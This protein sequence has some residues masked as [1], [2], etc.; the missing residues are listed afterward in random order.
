M[1]QPKHSGIQC[2]A[3]PAH[4]HQ[5]GAC[6]CRL[7]A[8]DAV[9]AH[10]L[11]LAAGTMATMVALGVVHTERIRVSGMLAHLPAPYQRQGKQT[12]AATIPGQRGL[13]LVRTETEVQ[14]PYTQAEN[15]ERDGGFYNANARKHGIGHEGIYG[16]YRIVYAY[17]P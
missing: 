3:I 4:A 8:T 11:H 15:Q 14:A 17:L 7:P 5:K 13:P 16:L 2:A 1:V 12:S 6:A 10:Q 9:H